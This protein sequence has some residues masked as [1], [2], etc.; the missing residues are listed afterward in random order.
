MRWVV[1]LFYSLGFIFLGL[2]LPL[3]VVVWSINCPRAST[4]SPHSKS[5]L[6][7]PEQHAISYVV[8]GD[9]IPYVVVEPFGDIPTQRGRVLRKQ[10]ESRG[11]N[12]SSFG[13]MHQHLILLHGR[14]GRKENLFALAERYCAVGYRCIIPDLPAHGES[15]M[16]KGYFGYGA[17]EQKL[18]VE[19]IEAE[20][21]ELRFKKKPVV[22]GISMGG[23]YAAH[24]VGRQPDLFE[25]CVLL[26]TFDTL[27]NVIKDKC[28]KQWLIS[29]V[30]SS[31][32]VLFQFDITRANSAKALSH[33]KVPLLVAHGVEDAYIPS[34]MGRRLY[35]GCPAQTKRWV[36]VKGANHKNILIT[37]YELHAEIVTFLKK[38]SLFN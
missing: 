18:L 20:E 12:N 35:E 25:A 14:N 1:L 22:W 37:D 3:L 27:E 28:K 8:K 6:N 30:L 36:E 23:A 32:K 7:T 13:E 4:L 31:A 17:L 19:M 33:S 16:K 21:R 38:N 10:L 9:E 34:A 11:I 24:L 15:L 5:W 26:S 29:F 2:A